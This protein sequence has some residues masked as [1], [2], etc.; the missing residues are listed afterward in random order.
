M[1]EADIADRL[2]L[3]EL[4]DRYALI[5]DDRNYALIDRVFSEDAVL[6]GPGFELTGRE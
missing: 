3:R 5:P 4:V 1:S 6:V 2:A